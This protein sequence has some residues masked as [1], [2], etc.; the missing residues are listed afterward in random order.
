MLGLAPRVV[1]YL[2]RDAK[3]ERNGDMSTFARTLAA[4]AVSAL[5]VA[6]AA[7]ATNGYFAIGYGAKSMGMGGVG[8]AFPQDSLA[9]SSNPAGMA[10]VGNRADLG[11]RLF[12]P[13]RSSSL[14][15]AALGAGGPTAKADSGATL[16]G[17]P[18]GGFV[19]Q[20][21]NMTMGLSVYGNGGMNTRFSRNIFDETAA[22][23]G[24]LGAFGPPIPDGITGT[25]GLNTGTLGVDLSQLIISPSLSMKMNDSHSIGAA[26]LI[27]VQRF[28]AYGLGNFQCF[29][30]TAN[31]TP[32]SQASCG[33]TGFPTVYSDKLTNQGHDYA[34]GAGVRVGWIGQLTDTISV[35]ATAASKIYMSKFDKYEEL[36]A[37]KGDFDIPAN[38]AVGIAVKI[39][40]KTTVAL[41]V[42]RILY[43]GVNSVSNVGPIA[44]ASGPTLGAGSGLLG[45]D[46]GLG[47]GWE[48]MTVYKLGLNH[49]YNSKLSVRAGFNY[50]EGP[51]EP[52]QVLFNVIAPGVVE[53][54]L[55]LGLTYSPSNNSEWNFAYMHA[56]K[57]SVE[58]NE[59]AFGVPG[60]LEMDQN[61][62]DV[63]YAFK[64]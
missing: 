58:T 25:G 7:H 43:E 45:A 57:E 13:N 6:P 23:L 31:S 47:F 40:P 5:L 52:S 36:F 15:V 10:L 12:N 17:I 9:A 61:S 22:N 29:T 53:R 20:A 18:N 48:D 11:F 26:L 54:H 27:G 38:F 33:T 28:S 63:S 37:E 16:F 14:D 46:N 41:D 55:T 49:E 64:F 56:F 35:G 8:V 24:Y 1:V 44:S 42:Q 34:Y 59:T 62:F 50:G 3:K 39:T 51:I 32:A 60:K 21:A 19:M 30:A 4:A 2:Q